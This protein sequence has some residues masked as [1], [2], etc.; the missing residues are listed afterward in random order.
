MA[1]RG[2]DVDR[3]VARG[4]DVA[5][6]A[7]LVRLVRADPGAEIV[8]LAVRAGE[9]ALKLV[10]ELRLAEVALLFRHPF[11]KPHVRRD[12][13]FGH[14]YSPG[15]RFQS[16]HVGDEDLRDPRLVSAGGHPALQQIGGVSRG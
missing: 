7:A 13:E 6:A 15:W 5:G 3:P 2:G 14:T 12:D 8:V 11:V 9:R 4:A 10:L 1:G 16:D